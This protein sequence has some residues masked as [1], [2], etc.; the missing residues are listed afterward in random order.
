MFDKFKA[1]TDLIKNTDPSKLKEMMGQAQE[2]K[3]MLDD[4]VRKMVDEE[5]QRRNLVSKEEVERMMGK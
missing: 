3:K 4:T 2:M 1:A 5:I